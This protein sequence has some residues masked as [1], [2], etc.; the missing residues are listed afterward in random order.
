MA[1]TQ[2]Q[3]H[4]RDMRVQAGGAHS[5]AVH[6]HAE[7]T[8][9]PLALLWHH[10]QRRRKSQ[11]AE[12]EQSV[13]TRQPVRVRMQQQRGRPAR[14]ARLNLSMHLSKAQGHILFLSQRRVDENADT[15]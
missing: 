10:V 8:H 9:T 7:H 3:V 14:P 12:D 6:A 13:A 2:L 4:V 1:N 11:R 15:R 5:H